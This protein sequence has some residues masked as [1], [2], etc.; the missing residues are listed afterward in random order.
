LSLAK[1]R[2]KIYLFALA[3]GTIPMAKERILIIE[4]EQDVRE[5]IRYNLNKEGFQ[6]DSAESGEIGLEMARES[7]P[8]LILLDLMLPDLDGLEVCR[9][10]KKDPKTEQ[11]P[12]IMVTAKGEEADIVSG[13]EL[14]ADDFV[15]KPFSP[16]VLLARI[17]AVLRRTSV[18][19]PDDKERI[20]LGDI[21]I[22]PGRFEVLADGEPVTLTHTE[23]SLLHYLARRPG[24][25]FSRNQIINAVRGDDYPVTDRSVDVQIVGLRKKLG[26]A[27]AR[28]ES[29]RG[30]G[31]RLKDQE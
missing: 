20:D 30:I 5:L 14:G 6:T 9:L 7:L 17:K 10:L 16:R 27:G 2:Q 21:V 8:G 28:I 11:I 12:I 31:Y 26:K 25:V 13:L 1:T 19:Q 22:D 24:W 23:F 4:D 15:P 3:K 18:K 29:V